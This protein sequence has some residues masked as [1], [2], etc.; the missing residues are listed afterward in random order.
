MRLR[1]P[2][3]GLAQYWVALRTLSCRMNHTTGALPLFTAC[4]LSLG[5]LQGVIRMQS[6]HTRENHS[7]VRCRWGVESC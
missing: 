5:A 6:M 7:K 2:A 3:V 1:T 4:V